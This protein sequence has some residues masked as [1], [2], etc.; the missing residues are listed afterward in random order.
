MGAYMT[1]FFIYMRDGKT[2]IEANSP[3]A[4]D[5]LRSSK[6]D[7][8]DGKIVLLNDDD[9]YDAFNAIDAVGYSTMTY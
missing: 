3:R 8:H 1:D 4:L 5:L 2:A 9:A 7:L 6:H